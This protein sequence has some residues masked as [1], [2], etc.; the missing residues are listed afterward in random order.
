MISEAE[1]QVFKTSKERMKRLVALN[2]MEVRDVKASN[3]SNAGLLR[4]YKRE[5]KEGQQK[6]LEDQCKAM[7]KSLMEEQETTISSKE[8]CITLQNSFEETK[9]VLED[10]NTIQKLSKTEGLP[11]EKLFGLVG[12]PVSHTV[13]NYTDPMNIGI[14]ENLK[15]VVSSSGFALNQKS[16]WSLS[17]S[18][19]FLQP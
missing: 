19:N 17:G 15:E 1:N 13:Q 3:K 9:D 14:N 7:R 2:A 16:L 12:I 10:D 18:Q 8:C 6:Q 4:R 5:H 11:W